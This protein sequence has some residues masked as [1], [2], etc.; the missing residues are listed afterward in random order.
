MYV[1]AGFENWTLNKPFKK[2]VELDLLLELSI[3]KRVF[4]FIC[5]EPYNK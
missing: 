5:L 1:S 3:S 2:T 4:F